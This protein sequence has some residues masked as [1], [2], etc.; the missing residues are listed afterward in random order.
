MLLDKWRFYI[1]QDW[2]IL[3]DVFDNISLETILDNILWTL[4]FYHFL[5]DYL[6]EKAPRFVYITDK[7]KL[8]I[9]LKNNGQPIKNSED[10]KVKKKLKYV[11]KKKAQYND[12]CTSV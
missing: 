2:E 12:L 9:E 7:L 8:A 1:S 4:S 3:G 5:S 10:E 11:I 6:E